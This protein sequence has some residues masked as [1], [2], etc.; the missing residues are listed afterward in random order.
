MTWRKILCLLW[1]WLLTVQNVMNNLL[2]ISELSNIPWPSN[3]YMK[4]IW[5]L[6]WVSKVNVVIQGNLIKDK[7][8]QTTLEIGN[9]EWW[10]VRYDFGIYSRYTKTFQDDKKPS[11][12]LKIIDSV[13]ASSLTYDARKGVLYTRNI[14]YANSYACLGF[15]YNNQ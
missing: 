1:L 13:E 2:S 3:N 6:P 11:M 4:S 8:R 9:P 5:K 12:S 15:I 14:I 10:F 7:E